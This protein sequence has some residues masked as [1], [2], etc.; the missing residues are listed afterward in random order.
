LAQAT[1][2]PTRQSVRARQQQNKQKTYAP[3]GSRCVTVAKLVAAHV[4][5]EPRLSC[6][7]PFH[8]RTKPTV[9]Y[10]CEVDVNDA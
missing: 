2:R 10:D 5:P 1:R 6:I 4:S 3:S 9:S 7:E 8:S